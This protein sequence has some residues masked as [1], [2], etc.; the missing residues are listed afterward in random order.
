MGKSDAESFKKR[1]EVYERFVGRSGREL[2]QRLVAWAGIQS[3][4]KVLDVGCGPGALSSVLAKEVGHE[5]VAAVDP[6]KPFASACMDRLPGADVR[7]ASAEELPFAGASFDA[8][9][10]QLVVNFLSDALA[11]LKEMRRVT[12]PGGLIAASVWDYAG[13]MTML[14][15]FWDAALEVDPVGAALLDDGKRMRYCEPGELAQLLSDAG[16]T[17]I[18]TD[19]ITVS[20]D[21]QD[22]E[23]LWMPFTTGVGPAG[24]YSTSLSASRR[25]ELRESYL[26][27]LGSPDGPFELTA[28]MGGARKSAPPGWLIQ[29]VALGVLELVGRN[30]DVEG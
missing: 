29:R 26:K 14:R 9:C 24:A 30:Q 19:E 17:E 18:V 12:R 16:L 2:A 11:G 8:T 27:R 5:K 21:Y 3:D 28:C 7:V 1:A 15:M 13:E 20:A 4:W 10:S 23:D 25:A 6:S 22:F